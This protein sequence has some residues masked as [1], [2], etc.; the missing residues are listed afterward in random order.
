VLAVTPSGSI[1]L[2]LHVLVPGA[3]AWLAFRGQWRTAWLVMVGTMLIDLDHLLAEPIYDPG[4]CS[5]GFHPLHT[6]PA[7]GAYA[8][9][10]LWPRARLVGVGLL[11]HV[12]LD[13]I[14]CLLM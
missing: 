8:L 10:A 6:G 1:H 7:I 2:L 9:L 14:D 13:A 12:A 11:I 4:R 5:I 3:V